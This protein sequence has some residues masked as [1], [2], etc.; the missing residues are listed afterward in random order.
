M[1]IIMEEQKSW[2]RRRYRDAPLEGSCTKKVKFADIVEELEMQFALAKF[3]SY[4]V[5]QAIK[6][7]FPQSSSKPLEKSRH[8][9]IFGIEPVSCE[10]MSSSLVSCNHAA[11]LELERA[12]NR[13]MQERVHHLEQQVSAMTDVLD[14]QMG[15]VLQ[16][17]RQVVH[18]PDTPERFDT[19]SIDTVI[20]ELQSN[21]PDLY[22][23][24]MTLAKTDRNR[25]SEDD[26][27][28][29]EQ[30]RAIMSMCSLLKARSV[31]VKGV[32]LLIS[33][34]LI[35]RATHRQVMLH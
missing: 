34:M 2:L 23:L 18:G 24:V 11:L 33:L 10:Q 17:G 15:S 1:F 12:K 35:A 26:G 9:Y 14:Q 3:S 21:A 7:V 28:N 4:T 19:F 22:Q 6:E 25:P 13:E 31:R 20:A 27:I 29:A 32:Q 16:H 30:C 8:K 5:L